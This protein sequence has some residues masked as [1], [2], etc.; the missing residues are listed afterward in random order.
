[1]REVQATTRQEDMWDLAALNVL[2]P[3]YNIVASAAGIL[4]KNLL[5]DGTRPI[6]ASR[7]VVFECCDVSRPFSAGPYTNSACSTET[8]A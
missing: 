4:L 5:L 2:P 6:V 3:P 8:F 7:R 1:M